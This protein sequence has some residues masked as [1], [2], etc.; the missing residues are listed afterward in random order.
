MSEPS[1][2][3]IAI[4][5]LFAALVEALDERSSGLAASFVHHLEE[6]QSRLRDGDVAHREALDTLA[7]TRALL[8][9]DLDRSEPAYL[10][11]AKVQTPEQEQLQA[12]DK[13][14]FP[15]LDEAVRFWTKLPGFDQ[16]RATIETAS[17]QRLQ[18]E[19][20]RILARRLRA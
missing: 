13:V 5:A 1:E 11:Y 19:A 16:P 18:A 6:T 15:T 7:W 12:F 14:P 3:Q 2:T 4:A 9:D 10:V 8:R 20:L 17:G